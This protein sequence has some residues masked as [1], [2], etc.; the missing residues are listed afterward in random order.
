MIHRAAIPALLA[1]PVLAGL[2][3]AM[4]H[5]ELRFCND[6]DARVSVAIGYSEGGVWTSEG[7]WVAEAG[8]C[9]NVIGGDLDKRY[10]YWRATSPEYSWHHER[11]MFCTSPKVFTIEGDENC[12]ARGYEREGFNQIDTGK[13]AAF[14]MTLNAPGGGASGPA[15]K[16]EGEEY[17]EPAAGDP[18]FGPAPA[19]GPAP[20][21]GTW[22]E[23][24]SI[25]G[26]LSHCDWY[27]AGMGCTILA[28]GWSYLATS[29]DH[30]PLAVLESLESAG[31]NRPIEI[32]GDMISYEGTEAIV[33]IREH[34]LAGRDPYARTRAAM[35]GYWVSTDDANYTLLI[36]GSSF[37]EY[38]QQAPQDLL[39]MHFADGCPGA[40]GS[41]PAFRLAARDGSEDRCVFV[42]PGGGGLLELFVA[43][44][45]RPL[46]FRR[47]E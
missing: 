3:P 40:P 12:A 4:A 31:P 41:G 43:G 6:T 29:Y 45:M 24:Y 23:P 21:P 36:H 30:T 7:W 32:S 1:G 22:G 19:S 25:A 10:Y 46:T 13:S 28:D 33:T 27:D 8:E 16:Q 11:Y 5:A 26:I 37:E 44:T 14:T 47:S 42:E 20:A 35:Q 34:R 9:M 38:Y 15:E 18:G 2:V 17:D 39:M